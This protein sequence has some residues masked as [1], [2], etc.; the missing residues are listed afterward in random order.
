MTHGPVRRPRKGSVSVYSEV[1]M[2]ETACS[3]RATAQAVGNFVGLW[4][5]SS[6]FIKTVGAR[7]F[8]LSLS[9]SLVIGCDDQGGDSG[10]G[11]DSSGPGDDDSDSGDTLPSCKQSC[12]SSLAQD[13]ANGPPDQA[14]CEADCEMF[15]AGPCAQAYGA[16]QACGG[17]MPELTCD[18]DGRV[19]VVGCEP[20]MTAFVACLGG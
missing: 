4:F 16:L 7:V 2:V 13:C 19:G 9:F 12:V 10:N 3:R 6:R 20:E 5:G 11:T 14:T 15:R 17:P 8:L 1:P 18:A